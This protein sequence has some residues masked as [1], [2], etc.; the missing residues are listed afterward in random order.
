[1]QNTTKKNKY[2]GWLTAAF[3]VWFVMN[4]RVSAGIGSIF[5]RAVDGLVGVAL[6]LAAVFLALDFFGVIG[7]DK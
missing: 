1:M 7:K 4:I 3:I 2:A 6:L 5:E